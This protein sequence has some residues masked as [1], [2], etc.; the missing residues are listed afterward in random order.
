MFQVLMIHMFMKA[1]FQ[2]E[3]DAGNHLQKAIERIEKESMR[4]KTAVAW[5]RLDV[6]SI[7]NEAVEGKS[8]RSVWQRQNGF[9]LSTSLEPCKNIRCFFHSKEHPL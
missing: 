1:D 7:Q 4:Y 2:Q 5:R 9:A 6:W 3:D 8:I